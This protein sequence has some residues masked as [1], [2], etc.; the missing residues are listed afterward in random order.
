MDEVGEVRGGVEREEGWGGRRG[1]GMMV[2]VVITRTY[3]AH[4]SNWQ[5]R[6]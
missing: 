3:E 1:E 2:I 6:S 5:K 4:C